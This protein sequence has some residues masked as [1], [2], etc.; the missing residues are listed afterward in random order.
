MVLDVDHFKEINDG[1][2]HQV[3]DEVLVG[4]CETV[5]KSLRDY[6]LFGRHGGDEFTLLFPETDQ[7][8]SPRH[9]KPAGG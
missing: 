2:G 3:G 9:R 1:L 5:K 8:S 4:I 7:V 6:D